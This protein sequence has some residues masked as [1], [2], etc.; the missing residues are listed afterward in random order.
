MHVPINHRDVLLLLQ[1][2]DINQNMYHCIIVKGVHYLNE[3]YSVKKLFTRPLMSK[4][5]C[6]VLLALYLFHKEL[7]ALE[8]T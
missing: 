1:C 8:K 3:H 7:T 2:I 4:D 6:I 5:T